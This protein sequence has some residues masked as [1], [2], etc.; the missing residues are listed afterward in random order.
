LESLTSQGDLLKQLSDE[1]FKSQHPGYFMNYPPAG[2]AAAQIKN[3]PEA[4]AANM[5]HEIYQSYPPP[6]IGEDG[7]EYNS[8][9]L[10]LREASLDAAFKRDPAAARVFM[11]QSALEDSTDTTEGDDGDYSPDRP[12]IAPLKKP[13]KKNSRFTGVKVK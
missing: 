9:V 7:E 2:T 13:G 4:R 3:S 10:R 12:A 6:M 8:R 5:I 11:K 1:Q